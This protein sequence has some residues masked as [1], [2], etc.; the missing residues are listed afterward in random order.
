MSLE[1]PGFGA[2]ARAIPTDFWLELAR[3]SK[4]VVSVGTLLKNLT[5]EYQFLLMR[6]PLADQKEVIIPRPLYPTEIKEI[7]RQ[8]HE[9][10]ESIRKTRLNPNASPF[11]P[12]G[13]F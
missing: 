13:K 10:V 4:G 12:S 1:V 2:T 8:K 9:K 5:R 3:R 7:E 11:V 6:N